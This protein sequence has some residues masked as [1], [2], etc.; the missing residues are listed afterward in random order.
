MQLLCRLNENET[1]KK[2]TAKAH[3][4]SLIFIIYWIELNK[5]LNNLGTD[6]GLNFL[7]FAR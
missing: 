7:Y 2:T 6:R 3:N 1:Q 5:P 4:F